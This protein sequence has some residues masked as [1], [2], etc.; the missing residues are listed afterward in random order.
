VVEFNES[1]LVQDENLISEGDSGLEPMGDHKYGA[2]LEMLEKVLKDFFLG[3]W[4]YL[5]G[6]LIE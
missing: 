1:P 2:L 3:L 5:R 4:I 6:R